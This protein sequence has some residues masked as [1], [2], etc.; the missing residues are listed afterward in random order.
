M[1]GNTERELMQNIVFEEP[2][3]EHQWIK[4]ATELVVNP[5]GIRI[6]LTTGKDICRGDFRV[7]EFH[8]HHMVLVDDWTEDR[9]PR[10]LFIPYR[11]VVSVER[12]DF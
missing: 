6:F 8:E 9:E 1:T 10:D 5:E 11:S 12:M 4:G 7:L 2:T 3:P